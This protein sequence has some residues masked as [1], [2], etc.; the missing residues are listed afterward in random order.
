MSEDQLVEAILSYQLDPDEDDRAELALRRIRARIEELR[1]LVAFGGG[2]GAVY[3]AEI[4]G[5]THAIAL[6]EDPAQDLL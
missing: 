6:L 3:A 1:P 2:L 5:L 4:Q